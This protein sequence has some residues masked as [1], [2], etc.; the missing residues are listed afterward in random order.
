LEDRF[1]DIAGMQPQPEV[2]LRP[3]RLVKYDYVAK[4]L[5][6]AQRLGVTKIGFV[7]NEQYME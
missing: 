4:V 5:S 1:V 7:G 2:H 3:N 6:A